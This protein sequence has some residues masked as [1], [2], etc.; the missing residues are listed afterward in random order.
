MCTRSDHGRCPHWTAFRFRG[1]W[2]GRPVPETFLCD[3][4][5]HAGCPLA[6]RRTVPQDTWDQQ[7]RCAGAVPARTSMARAESSRQEMSGIWADVDLT[8]HPRAEEVE[9]RLR[10]AYAAHGKP[11]PPFGLTT[12]SRIIA[13]S[14]A[15]RGT[16]RLR[17]LGLGGRAVA[18]AVRW[19]RE[20]A[21]GAGAH[22]RSELRRMYRTAGVLAGA[23]ALLSGLAVASSGWRRLPC[24]VLAALS[25]AA[26]AWTAAVTTAVA[27]VAR[28]EAGQGRT[29]EPEVS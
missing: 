11:L 3:C 27:Q 14:T 1:I 2:R 5:C 18:R 20:P 26:A 9:R 24:A 19:S 16:R 25:G 7:C 10:A 8:D 6:G 23:A 15:R 29:D 12:G 21:T 13:A 22:N 4:D 17:L 28:L